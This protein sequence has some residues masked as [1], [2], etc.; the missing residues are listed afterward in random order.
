MANNPLIKIKRV[1]RAEEFFRLDALRSKLIAGG[2]PPETINSFLTS[3]LRDS[4]ITTKAGTVYE[5]MIMEQTV[6][7]KRATKPCEVCDGTG[8]TKIIFADC[9][10][11]NGTGLEISKCPTCKGTGIFE[12]DHCPDCM[13]SGLFIPLM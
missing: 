2:N 5:V 8:K 3:L 4:K 10:F 9:P 7:F 13:G 12:D 11:C 1:D 6:N